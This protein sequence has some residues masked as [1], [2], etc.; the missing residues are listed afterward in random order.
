MHP[1]VAVLSV[2]VAGY[3]AVC[4]LFVA[5]GLSIT[6][7]LTGV[8]RWDNDVVRWFVG[9]R[10]GGLNHWATDATRVADTFGIL[11]VLVAA[12]F[13]LLLLR[14]F[15]DAIFLVLALVLELSAFLTVNSI[16]HRPRPSV[17][18][19]GSLPST[20][21]FPSGH[22]AAMVALYGG[23]AVILSA[24]FRSWLVAVFSWMIAV[25]SAAMI[26]VARVYSAMH[27]PTDV[28]AG[29]LLGFAVLSVAVVAV[30]VGQR[31][32]E[33]HKRLGHHGRHVA[34]SDAAVDLLEA[35]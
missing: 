13:V 8:T 29:A 34:Q 21:S 27:H 35:S 31:S 7:Q 5:V 12:T 33:E 2:V 23:L 20:S 32:V 10:T 16:V 14:Y 22:T 18:R 15:W 11:I 6:H 19:L 9:D 17:P 25:G 24:R 4:V 28:V 3:L 30:H 1:V 26:G